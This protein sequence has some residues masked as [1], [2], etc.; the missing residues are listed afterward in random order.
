MLVLLQPPPLDQQPTPS[1]P[2]TAQTDSFY[3]QTVLERFLG[4]LLGRLR[5]AL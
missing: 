5:L 3:P 2:L 4:D 1:Q